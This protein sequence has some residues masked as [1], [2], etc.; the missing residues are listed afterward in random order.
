MTG[1]VTG[2]L[3]IADVDGLGTGVETALGVNVGSAGAFVTNGGALGTPSSGTLNNCVGTIY[4]IQAMAG[5]SNPV[6]GQTV[7]FGLSSTGPQTTA[8]IHVVPIPVAGTVIRLD[9]EVQVA[10]TLGDAATSAVNFRLNNTT[11]TQITAAA[12]YTAV[13]QAYS[14]TVSIT[15]AA[16]DYFQIKVANPTWATTNP[17]VVTYTCV[18]TVRTT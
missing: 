1:A 10:G 9:F 12:S 11:D 18:V 14:A 4:A 13:R 16:G 6:D 7:Y 2:T 8:A 5:A 17:T 3:D 15:V